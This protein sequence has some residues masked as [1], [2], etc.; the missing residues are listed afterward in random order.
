MLFFSF[1][2]GLKI[3]TLM[4]HVR[5]RI[6]VFVRN[7]NTTV[8]C[9]GLSVFVGKLRVFPVMLLG[10]RFDSL[11]WW[12]QYNVTTTIVVSVSDSC[13][14]V[15]VLGFRVFFFVFVWTMKSF[16]FA[17]LLW[18]TT[19]LSVRITKLL[20]LIECYTFYDY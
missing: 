7:R 19:R 1:F 20:K 5:K 15:L 17:G 10:F 6:C 3:I 12:H 16:G 8:L 14:H 18:Y 11:S 9:Y 4:F 2:L 13:W